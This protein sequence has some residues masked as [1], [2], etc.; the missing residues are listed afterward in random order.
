MWAQGLILCKIRGAFSKGI[1]NA[2][3]HAHDLGWLIQ[4]QAQAESA[5]LEPNAPPEF[6]HAKATILTKIA[7]GAR[8]PNKSDSAFGVEADSETSS[9]SLSIA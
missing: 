9:K 4:A 2:F 7:L 6:A 1:L 8:F 5:I 3:L